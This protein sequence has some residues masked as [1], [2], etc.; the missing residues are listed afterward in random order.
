MFAGGDCKDRG[1]TDEG[2]RE[3]GGIGIRYVKSVKN[4]KIVKSKLN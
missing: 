3:I 1:W 2:S 4:Q